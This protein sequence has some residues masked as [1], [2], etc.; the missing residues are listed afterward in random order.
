MKS[1]KALIIEGRYDSLVTQLSNRLF[2]VIKDSYAAAHSTNG[3][4]AGAKIF[5]K[6]GETVPHIEDDATQKRV[7][8]E[9]IENAEIP[10]EFYLQLKIQWIEGLDDFRSGGDAFNDSKRGTAVDAPLIEIRFQMDPSEYPK[11]LNEVA[12]QLRDTLRHEIEHITQSGWN[13]I[14][15][16]YIY[17]DQALRTKIESGK[18]PAARYFTLP[19]ETPAMLQGMYFKAKKS[20]IPF[21]K[22]INDYLDVWVDNNTITNQDKQ[23]ILKTWRNYL[24]KLGIRQEI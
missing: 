2:R 24:P 11:I 8:F 23:Y 7:F 1:L 13:T 10:V 4:F 6:K 18:L 15:G 22:V 20:K 21:S 17:S 19:K 16:K 12:M 5:Y 14:D 9:E 3:E